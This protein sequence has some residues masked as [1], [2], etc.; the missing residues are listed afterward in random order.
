MS[1]FEEQ[2]E[3]EII[4]GGNKTAPETEKDLSTES[5]AGSQDPYSL[6]LD[7]RENRFFIGGYEI[8]KDMLIDDIRKQVFFENAKE[9]PDLKAP[10]IKVFL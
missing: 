7:L 5:S 2:K 8:H 6:Q 10:D 1:S 3:R 4:E 9:V